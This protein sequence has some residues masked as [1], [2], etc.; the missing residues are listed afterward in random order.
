[1]EK[2]IHVF[3][4]S[5]DEYFA[6]TSAEEAMLCAIKAWG[7]KTYEESTEEFGGPMEL[8]DTVLSE[9]PFNDDGHRT[10]FREKLDQMIAVGDKFPTY[11][12]SG[13][14]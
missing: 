10:T 3:E 12:A 13:N 9:M 8:D 2:T 5:D 14:L 4:V 1:M 7:R 6:A 11:F